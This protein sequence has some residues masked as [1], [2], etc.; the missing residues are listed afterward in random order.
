MYESPT[1]IDKHAFVVSGGKIFTFGGKTFTHYGDKAGALTYTRN[2][3]LNRC[4]IYIDELDQD[5]F[6]PA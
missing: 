2:A 3:T 1:V 6:H 4:V 5:S